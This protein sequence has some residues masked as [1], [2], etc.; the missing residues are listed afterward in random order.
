MIFFSFIF[1]WWFFLSLL[2]FL[3]VYYFSF[4]IHYNQGFVS[5]F[6]L[7]AVCFVEYFY[8]YFFSLSFIL[9]FYFL[10]FFF[11]RF[12][13]TRYMVFRSI[14]SIDFNELFHSQTLTYFLSTIRILLYVDTVNICMCVFFNR[15]RKRADTTAGANKSFH[16]E[17]FVSSV[18]LSVFIVIKLF[19]VCIYISM[20]KMTMR[21]KMR[22]GFVSWLITHEVGFF[23]F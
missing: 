22:M 21:K 9:F 12:K 14:P 13:H 15:P 20:F 11:C 23:F 10:L 1:Y 19:I 8:W 3:F 4:F 16:D 7:H 18:Y 6:S 5:F 17:N 2:L